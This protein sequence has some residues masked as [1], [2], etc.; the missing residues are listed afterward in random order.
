MLKKKEVHSD[1]T[2]DIRDTVNNIT[3]TVLT[4]KGLSA[5]LKRQ[6]E[7][8]E[9]EKCAAEIRKKKGPSNKD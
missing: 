1:L 8:A 7:Y 6:M 5:C 3:L 4:L 2:H 9:R